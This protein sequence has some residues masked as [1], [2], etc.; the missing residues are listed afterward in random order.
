MTQGSSAYFLPF[1]GVDHDNDDNDNNNCYL[2]A[3]FQELAGEVVVAD[4]A[5]RVG[6]RAVG[7]PLV[8]CLLAS[9]APRELVILYH[10]LSPPVTDLIS[11][12]STTWYFSLTWHTT[13][14]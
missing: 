13:P 5:G 6:Q 12:Y 14:T 8:G 10:S 11:E 3:H 9:V 7:I 1:D 4:V 2:P